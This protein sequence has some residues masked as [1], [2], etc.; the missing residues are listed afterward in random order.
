MAVERETASWKDDEGHAL[1][2][3]GGGGLRVWG[4]GG[5]EE[6]EDEGRP[7]CEKKS[8]DSRGGRASPAPPQGPHMIQP[9]CR[10]L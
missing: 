5:E 8:N 9:S 2:W 6:V 1:V 3:D 4:G 7:K 10:H